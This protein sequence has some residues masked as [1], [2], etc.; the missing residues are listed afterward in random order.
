MPERARKSDRPLDP[1]KNGN[2]MEKQI[3]AQ[4]KSNIL[5]S[6]WVAAERTAG[7]RRKTM[8]AAAAATSEIALRCCTRFSPLT[9]QD[10]NAATSLKN[11]TTAAIP[12]IGARALPAPNAFAK[13]AMRGCGESLPHASPLQTAIRCAL[14]PGNAYP[15]VEQM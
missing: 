5:G 13:I 12:Q 3:S 9:R 8:V 6:R 4:V 10:T 14:S 1:W 2:A 7:V 15:A 11:I